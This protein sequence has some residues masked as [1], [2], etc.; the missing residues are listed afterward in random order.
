MG[1]KYKNDELGLTNEVQQNQGLKT[2]EDVDSTNKK[3]VGNPVNNG[4][5][6]IDADD[7][8]LEKQWLAVRDEYLAKFPELNEMEEEFKT[9]NI[10]ALI[11]SI[12][13]KRKQSPQV[14]AEEIRSWELSH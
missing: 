6:N 9:E 14:I 1:T 10:G 2:A 5:V 8:H 7:V 11:Q 4:G 12:A 13:Q 3:E